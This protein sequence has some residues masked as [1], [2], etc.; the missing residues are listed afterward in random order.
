MAHAPVVGRSI[1]DR[2]PWTDVLNLAQIELL[3]RYRDAGDDAR[4]DLRGVLQAS[5]NAIAAA[6]Q[7]TG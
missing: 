2:N 7:S 3:K 5:I 6:M 4:E 1:D